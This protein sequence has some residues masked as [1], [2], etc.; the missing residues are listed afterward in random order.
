MTKARAF[1]ICDF[2]LLFGLED[3][4]EDLDFDALGVGVTVTL[5]DEPCCDDL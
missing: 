5:L 2:S 3:P 1:A 4:V